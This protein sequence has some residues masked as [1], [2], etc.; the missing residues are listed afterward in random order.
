M[1][2]TDNRGERGRQSNFIMRPQSGIYE[3]QKLHDIDPSYKNYSKE[4]YMLEKK[5][6]REK[7]LRIADLEEEKEEAD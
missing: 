3:E 1:A 5:N 6:E 7:A 4:K 2:R